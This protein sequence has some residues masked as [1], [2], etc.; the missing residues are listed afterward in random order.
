M[1]TIYN[2]DCFEVFSY[3]KQSSIDLVLT[4][5]PYGSTKCAWDC[6]ID[7]ELLW[8]ELLRIGRPNCAYLFFAT[9]PFASR[10]IASNMKMFK[11][12]WIWDKMTGRGHLV[13]KKRPLAQHEL[14]LTFYSSPPVYNPQMVLR[15]KPVRGK[16]CRRTDIM[17]GE[18]VGYE[19]IY[20]HKYPK[21]II[22][23]RM[24]DSRNGHP[25][26]K[27]VDLLEY[28][29]K[30]YTNEGATVLDP[31]CG[32]GST[33]VACKNLKRRYI[34]IEKDEKWFDVANDRLITMEGQKK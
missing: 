18:S 7:L 11:Y 8:K 4:D 2:D 15:D 27:P 28:F 13:A 32:S 5:P 34:G 9:N 6:E 12:D 26:Q 33:L 20:T 3:L 21:T 19:K 17:G 16:E 22:S 29:V 10:L 23:Q 25:T 24:N 1:N 30:T 14:V 31:F